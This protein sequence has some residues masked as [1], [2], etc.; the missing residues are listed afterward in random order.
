[1]RRITRNALIGAMAGTVMLGAGLMAVGELM[2]RL[3]LDT[4]YAHWM[5]R[6]MA[7]DGVTAAYLETPHAD[8]DEEAEAARWFD[9]T[10]QPVRM[11]GEDGTDLRGWLFDPD[12][13]SPAPHLYAISLHG[14]SGGPKDMAK[15]AH[16]F[17]RMGFTVLVPAQ[18]AH[19]PSGGRYIGMGWLE[20][21]DLLGWISLIVAS[22]PDARILLHGVSMG[23]ATVMMTTGDPSLPRNVEAAIEDCGYTSVWD[24]F[25]F[26]AKGMYHLPYRWMGGPVVRCMSASCRRA[27]GYGFREATCLPSLR[28]TIIPMMFIHG[29]ADTFVDPAF[30]DRN[31]A[32]CASI[33][34]EVLVVPGATH[35]MAAS[36]D[37]VLYWR[38]VTAFVQRVFDL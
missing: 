1:M 13:A 14:Y 20:R 22:D 37:P 15:Y 11:R 5:E 3:S 31:V 9:R 27:A 19:E 23:A 33:D 34:R 35:A 25:L 10:R 17:A 21:G 8:A 18:R 24:Q 2:F 7:R 26:N 36:T 4:R 30:L 29:D 38:R 12:C 6:L 28:R 16:R 32:A